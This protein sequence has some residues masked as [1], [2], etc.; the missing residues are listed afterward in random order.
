MSWQPAIL[1]SIICW[2]AS[3]LEWSHSSSGV[4]GDPPTLHIPTSTVF[5]CLQFLEQPPPICLPRLLYSLFPETNCFAL[6]CLLVPHR[7][8]F[9]CPLGQLSPARACSSVLLWAFSLQASVFSMQPIWPLWTIHFF[10]GLHP[11][12]LFQ[13]HVLN[14]WYSDA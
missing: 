12:S 5:T 1:L 11:S 13:H 14:N 6:L 2:P 10:T 3:H 7:L 8:N 9:C 4:F